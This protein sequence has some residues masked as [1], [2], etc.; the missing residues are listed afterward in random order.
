MN[1]KFSSLSNANCYEDLRGECKW[2]NENTNTYDVIENDYYSR[3]IIN[4][5]ILKKKHILFLGD[6][7]VF[8]HGITHAESMGVQFEEFLDNDEYCII[9]LGIPGTSYERAFLRLQQWC[10]QFGDNIHSVYFGISH[11]LRKMH[12]HALPFNAIN[13]PNY[14]ISDNLYDTIDEEIVDFIPSQVPDAL[15]DGPEIHNVTQAHDLFYKYSAY[16]P[17]IDTLTQ[18]DR[19]VAMLKTQG[20]A[21]Q[22]NT[23]TFQTASL[24]NS[25]AEH[26]TIKQHV[27]VL[28]GFPKFTYCLQQVSN[29][30][31][32]DSHVIDPINNRHWNGLGSKQVAFNLF[33]ETKHWYDN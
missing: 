1:R 28:E 26:E 32:T 24:V 27:D 13:N 14:I 18:W 8:G 10:N 20:K 16:R 4:D 5:E 30:K 2:K 11:P 15:Y 9:N 17:A 21:Y 12:V 3:S 23:C 22:F 31:V 29:V 19:Q 7:F 33:K 25:P 6:S